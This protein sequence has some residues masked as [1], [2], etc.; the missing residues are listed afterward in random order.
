MY[1]LNYNIVNCRLNRPVGRPFVPTPRF[2]EFSGS[3][4]VAIPGTVF[5]NGYVNVFNQIN[6]FDDI[7]A[8]IREGAVLDYETGQYISNSATYSAELTQSIGVTGSY[9]ANP[10]SNFESENYATSL[11]FTGSIAVKLSGDS[12]LT[13]SK[14]GTNLGSGSNWCIE[15]WVAFDV[16]SSITG[17]SGSFPNDVYFGNPN[18]VLAQK[19]REGLIE[20]SSYLTYVGW[21]GKQN[22][23]AEANL[24]S[25][26]IALYYDAPNEGIVPN[27]PREWFEAPATMSFS[28]QQPLEWRHY[29]IS[30][31]T[32]SVEGSSGFYR[33]YI[34]GVLQ[35]SASYDGNAG[36]IYNSP[37][38]TLLFGDDGTFDETSPLYSVGN[39]GAYFQDFRM[40]NG[41]N[42]NYTG[43]LIT[44][45]ESMIIG[46]KPPYPQ[47]NP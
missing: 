10:L 41:S 13:S 31:S 47:Y 11:Y 1:N 42:K 44:V 30:Y 19:Y 37:E 20:S 2:D 33:F 23:I 32:G 29:A 21:A 8:Y 14:S 12:E 9:E 25:G 5:K 43:S 6:A 17:Q 34:D 38:A 39:N 35:S 22:N 4:V 40:Y 27:I 26:S 7:S 24:I 36:Q 45:P 16:T 15:T 28:V 46:K 18:R 3:L